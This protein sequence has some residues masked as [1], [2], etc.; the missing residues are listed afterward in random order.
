M[1][2]SPRVDL[3]ANHIKKIDSLTGIRFYAAYV[4]LL[5]HLF[6][7]HFQ[8]LGVMGGVSVQL[9]F[10]LSGFVMY[11]SYGNKILNGSEPFIRY[12]LLRIARLY[13]VYFLVLSLYL[14]VNIWLGY[15]YH[16]MI[17][18]YFINLAMIQSWM[19]DTGSAF[20]VLNPPSWSVSN[21]MFFYLTFFLCLV[22]FKIN[23]RFML[24]ICLFFIVT[25]IFIFCVRNGVDGYSFYWLSYVNPLYRINDFF[26]GCLLGVLYIQACNLSIQPAGVLKKILPTMSL[27]L[28]IILYGIEYFIPNMSWYSS[29]VTRILACLFIMSLLY[30]H[31]GVVHWVL[32]KKISVYLGECSYSLYL[33][34][35]FV[36]FILIP[37]LFKPYIDYIILMCCMKMIF[38]ILFSVVIYKYYEKPIYSV[39]RNKIKYS[40]G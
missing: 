23:T 18:L 2:Q 9:F 40:R 39:L 38:P 17:R 20:N 22:V 19:G 1:T 4:V 15:D 26:A 11:I 35:H 7:P 30:S 3:S 32:S 29:I 37:I 27:I 31:N 12:L 28:V 25:S 16:E 8:Y 36:I 34:H 21:E 13:P 5:A 33:I 24:F 14:V 10:V 6:G